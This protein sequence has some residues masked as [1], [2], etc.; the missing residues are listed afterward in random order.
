MSKLPLNPTEIAAYYRERAPKVAHTGAEWRGP[1]PIH[2]GTDDNFT[3]N[4]NTGMAYCH[5]QCGKGWSIMQLENAVSGKSWKECRRDINEIVGRQNHEPAKWREV[6]H[7]DY[8]DA[9]GQMLFQ[10]VRLEP[11]TFRQRRRVVKMDGASA[12]VTWEYNVK[13][14]HRVLY[15]LPKV[16]SAD[17]VLLV[18]GEK[19]VENLEKLGFTATC[20]P[21]G[22]CSNS[23]KWLKNYS[24]S[25]EGKSV[26][27]L[28]DNDEPG[29]HHAQIVFQALRFRARELRIVKIPTGKDASDW[30]AA[31][32][33]RETIEQAIAETPVTGGQVAQVTGNIP[34]DSGCA[35][36]PSP[37]SPITRPGGRPAIPQIQVTDR[38]FRTI[39]DDTLDALHAANIPPRLFKRTCRIVGID[40]SELGRP[41]INELSDARLRHHLSRAADFF[42][43][44]SHGIRRDVPPPMD[45]T[46]D[47]RFQDPVNWRLPVLD[48]VIEAPTIRTDGTVLAQPGYDPQSQL[49]LIPGAGLYDL[50]IPDV[51]TRDHLDVSV[52]II[53]NVFTDFP[54]V[55]QASR[56]NVIAALLTA[57]CRH[58]IRGPVPLALFDATSQGTGKTLLAEVIALILTGRPAELITPM[59]EPEELR[60]QLTSMLMESP[61]LV[62]IDNV[63]S[64]VD[65]PAL[66]KV[67]TGDVH[68]DRVLGKS[69][70]VIMPVR[71]SW[72]ATGNNLQLGGDIARRCFW[73]RMDAGMPE[74]FRR[75]G[76]QHPRL[77]E[78]VLA[79]RRNLLIALLTLARAWFA[80]GQPRTSV[81]PVGSFEHWTEVVGGILEYAGVEG[82]LGNS[83]EMFANS[84]GERGEWEAFLDTL[85]DAFEER[86]FTVA[87]LWERL[88]EQTYEEIIRRSV[89]SAQADQLREALPMDLSR[90]MDR[91]GV[92]K[93]RLGIALKQRCGQRFGKRQLAIERAAP[94]SGRNVQRWRVAPNA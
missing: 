59:E 10:V 85:E 9:E 52:E 27:I 58:I 40:T 2:D 61:P 89:L 22:A 21:G 69:Q 65:W 38:P 35:E 60:K 63:T 68:R 4:P 45:V 78:H 88:N 93:Q 20:N 43:V 11:K 34:S 87:Q 90:W 66:A 36:A 29:S 24:D 56:A 41:F 28:P 7:Y 73:I 42:E 14:V 13:G 19:D 23:G 37:G 86:P 80:A 46:R 76:F 32:A 71:C 3:V 16:I 49:Y 30:I 53:R 50:D 12:G 44:N 83:G 94:D 17:Q 79:E 33:T 82:F 70:S 39:C 62:I 18:E 67:I 8:T 48:A 64:T 1:C 55:D 92:F 75:S 72:I 81:P 54:F 77:K 5:S 15:R 6:A 26:V 91:E 84:D 47:I 57:F 25:L 74:P 31:G 51:P